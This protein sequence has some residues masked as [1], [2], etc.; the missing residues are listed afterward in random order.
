MG[1]AFSFRVKFIVPILCLLLGF[2]PL[3]VT[4]KSYLD[5]LLASLDEA[6]SKENDYT[7][8]KEKRL[9]SLKT[10]LTNSTTH[11]EKFGL[12]KQIFDE[13]K[14]F[15]CDSAFHYS[16]LAYSLAQK[17][18]NSYWANE[19]RLQ[20]SNILTISG[21]YPESIELLTS[22]DKSTLDQEQLINYYTNF[23]H[24]YTEWGEY[25]EYEYSQKY[26]NM[27]KVFQDSLLAI[28]PPNTFEYTIEHAWKYI[29]T[30]KYEEAKNLLYAQ[31]PLTKKDTRDYSII[32][33]IIGILYWYQDDMEKHKTYLA[34]SAIS[35]IKASIKENTSLRSLAN[36]L[37]NEGDLKRANS[38]IK[39]S[40]NDANFYNARLRSIQISKSYPIIESAYQLE[41]EQ[42]KQKLQTL[43]LIISVLSILLIIT[44]FYIIR[45]FRKLSEARKQTLIINDQLKHKN[46]SLAEA[47]RIK[48]EYLGRFLSLCST[49]IEKME[50]HHRTLNK[51]AK[52]GHLEELFKVLK[53]NQFIEDELTEFYHN[54]D[55]AF[56]NIFPNFVDQFN[57]LL[58]GE[59]RIVLKQEE[60]LNAELRVFALIRLGITDSRKIAEFLRY[61]ITTIYNYRSKYRN[62]SLV[63]RDQFELEVMKISSF[64]P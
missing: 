4:A 8:S 19:S 59:D 41:R 60:I 37:F 58:A 25:A 64:K 14:V 7:S 55:N 5:S 56:L 3:M 6:I 23:Y 52:E 22:I 26:K 21:M 16:Q 28:I 12:Y 17:T 53:S 43:L 47:N 57:A 40:M 34:L 48:E 24:A 30:A 62:K 44:I 10:T 11:K 45:Q 36:I 2:N 50:K 29:E 18:A 51:R 61:S 27:G 13:Y 31:L 1:D 20:T 39:K 49:Y 33:S 63:P 38:Y 9:L 15:I 32:T 54:F 35:D 46:D 42:Q